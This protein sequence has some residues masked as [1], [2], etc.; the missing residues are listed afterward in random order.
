[1]PSSTLSTAPFPR[2]DELCPDVI[3]DDQ[4]DLSLIRENLKFSPWERLLANDDTVNFCDMARAAMKQ[5][6]AAA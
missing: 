4:I 1:M 3:G 2:E 5:A 6:H